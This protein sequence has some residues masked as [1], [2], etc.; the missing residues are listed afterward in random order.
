M[1]FFIVAVNPDLE[2]V[3][4]AAT[5]RLEALKLSKQTLTGIR[6]QKKRAPREKVEVIMEESAAEIIAEEEN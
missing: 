6:K 3:H 5:K 4:E 1:F 2:R